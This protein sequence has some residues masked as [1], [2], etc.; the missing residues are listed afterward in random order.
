MYRAELTSVTQCVPHAAHFG[1]ANVADRS[2]ISG[3]SKRFN[4]EFPCELAPEVE[5]YVQSVLLLLLP[6]WELSPLS[7][8]RFCQHVEENKSDLKGSAGYGY[9]SGKYNNLVAFGPL[10]YYETILANVFTNL[11]WLSSTC[12]KDELRKL[13]N[14][15]PKDPRAFLA[16]NLHD[17]SIGV[18]L[19]LDWSDLL[20]AD[21]NWKS[22]IG[23]NPFTEWNS[24]FE[25]LRAEQVALGLPDKWAC[26]DISGAD[27]YQKHR[28]RKVF[29]KLFKL[30]K[31]FRA[32]FDTYMENLHIRYHLDQDGFVFLVSDGLDSGK[33]VTLLFNTIYTIVCILIILHDFL[34]TQTVALAWPFGVGGDDTLICW[35]FAE[36]FYSS[37]KRIIYPIT[38]QDVSN[39]NVIEGS[40]EVPPDTVPLEQ[41]QLYSMRFLRLGPEY[42]YRVVPQT[43]RPNK[44]LARLTVISP[45]EDKC[46]LIEQLILVHYWHPLVLSVLRKEYLDLF[47]DSALKLRAWELKCL[48]MYTVPLFEGGV[49]AIK[50]KESLEFQS[51]PPKAAAPKKKPIMKKVAPAPKKT[52]QP[53]RKQETVYYPDKEFFEACMNPAE[54]ARVH[55]P[56]SSAESLACAKQMLRVGSKGDGVFVL[57]H[58]PHN[59]LWAKTAE[60]VEVS[61]AQTMT[62]RP[63]G[64]LRR[65]RYIKSGESQNRIAHLIAE[66]KSA[67]AEQWRQH[68]LALRK[69]QAWCEFDT[70]PGTTGKADTKFRRL[71]TGAVR[72]RGLKTWT[73]A[74]MALPTSAIAFVDASKANTGNTT[75]S[76]W[77]GAGAKNDRSW[78]LGENVPIP[79]S[80][81]AVVHITCETEYGVPYDTVPATNYPGALCYPMKAG[82]VKFTLN[83]NVNVA[84]STIIGYLRNAANG[85]AVATFTTAIGGPQQICTATLGADYDAVVIEIAAT[86]PTSAINYVSLQFVPQTDL[87]DGEWQQIACPDADII[88]S[89]FL[90][91]RATCQSMLGSFRG[92]DLNNQ[93]N[94]VGGT[95]P[96]DYLA[97]VTSFD[98][99][100]YANLLN[101]PGSL[102]GRAEKG[103]NIWLKPYSNQAVFLEDDEIFDYEN[104]PQPRISLI[105]QDVDADAALEIV[106]NTHFEGPSASQLF[107]NRNYAGDPAA[108]AFAES[109]LASIPNVTENPIHLLIF[110]AAC[111]AWRA[112]VATFHV[113]EA[114][115]RFGSAFQTAYKQ[116][117]AESAAKVDPSK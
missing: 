108:L 53:A 57:N 69:H 64:N 2:Y 90:G 77:M 20:T 12:S 86:M 76:F 22:V 26:A 41:A 24:L 47:P 11:I 67:L 78:I 34:V 100:N 29:I 71:V 40:N 113:I 65:Q 31:R 58:Q 46:A 23:L 4:N 117:F 8:A 1:V 37:W 36:T 52:A 80:P 16:S 84:A 104:V 102:S 66:G 83:C 101:I 19:F 27:K 116:T 10:N 72:P 75:Q 5:K 6:S 87:P 73:S 42:S 85:T 48:S 21:R 115:G 106:I 111:V 39:E 33:F 82:A 79:S 49:E 61:A 81:N 93:G 89:A 54:K 28:L 109:A 50:A 14:G 98:D 43:T 32:L 114:V 103:R 91:T 95:W 60:P 13:V 68:Y 55:L 88:S 74:A 63:D 15:L 62:V 7:G 30:P 45:N 51:M 94:T 3:Y 112:A 35:P 9:A 56:T 38:G 110:S 70:I 107:Q 17:F 25:R 44:A 96:K 105:F 97:E 18:I 92:S 59:L 99:L